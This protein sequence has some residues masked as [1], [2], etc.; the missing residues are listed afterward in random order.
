MKCAI[1][2]ALALA[3][4]P[5]FAAP[6]EIKVWRHDTSDAEMAA[7]RAAVDRFNRS[8]AQWKVTVEAIPQGSY[9]EAITAAS[10]VSQLP[11]VIAIDQP[12]VPNFAWAKHI[13]P[14]DDLLPRASVEPLLPG[15]RGSYFGKLYS[16]GQFDVALVL[17]SRRSRLEALGVRIATIEH[18]YTAQ[19]FR[20][21]L[22]K[23]KRS[24]QYRFPLDF[25]GRAGGEMITYTISPWFGSGG[26]DLIDRTNYLHAD[27]VLN[28]DAALAV[29]R[30]YAH[31]FKDKLAERNPA[32]V[33]G[34]LMGR[35]L[36]HYTG[37]W[38]ARQYLE[39][40]GDDLVVMPPPD[41]GHGPRIGAGSWQ[42][43]VTRD[44]KA[45]K[46]GAAFIA[47]LISPPEMAA[48]SRATSLIPVSDAA[49][50]LTDHYRP[51]GDWRIYF[52]FA[53]RY[54]QARPA[55]PAYPVIS[56]A[57]DKAM[58]DLRG[59]RDAAEALDDAVETIDRNIARNNGYG[60]SAVKSGAQQ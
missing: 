54:A 33:H 38:W 19:E 26:A 1:V 52:D 29:A 10:M 53:A 41:F 27:G 50:A 40:F 13:R 7:S 30:Y 45:P 46:G 59:G 36:F 48:M 21:I 5:C 11:C 49:A 4:Q 9:T 39:H 32:D 37:S 15:G 42:W 23:V 35:A 60:F 56:S 57:F 47:H 28:S 20:D 55:T 8:Q 17:Y 14:L 18:P 2:V 31:L 16:V 51:G 12:L 34:F 24:K 25:N 22:L 44:C 3:M 6:V 58:A 43:A